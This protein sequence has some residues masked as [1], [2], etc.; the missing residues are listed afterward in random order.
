MGKIIGNDLISARR[1]PGAHI[2]DV[3]L[4][5]LDTQRQ[6][7]RTAQESSIARSTRVISLP[8]ISIGSSHL[9]AAHIVQ[10]IR[11]VKMAGIRYGARYV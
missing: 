10:P 3:E 9:M 7:L 1:K 6:M 5:V 2:R 4:V 8:F 11:F